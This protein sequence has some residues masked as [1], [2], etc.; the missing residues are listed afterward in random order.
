MGK[1]MIKT[2]WY[3]Y[4]LK[5]VTRLSEQESFIILDLNAFLNKGIESLPHANWNVLN[6]TF[7]EPDGVNLWSFKL[8]LFALK[9]VIV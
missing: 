3:Y 9:E 1:K 6:P 4:S 5:S 8:R 7:L 2:Y